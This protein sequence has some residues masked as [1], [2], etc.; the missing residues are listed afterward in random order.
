MSEVYF[1]FQVPASNA[2]GGGAETKT[3]LKSVTD[4]RTYVRTY[5]RTRVKLYAPPTSWREA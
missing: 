2:L 3:V 4:V 5:V 1:K